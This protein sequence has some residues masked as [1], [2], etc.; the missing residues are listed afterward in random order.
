[1]GGRN[2]QECLK[3]D[4]TG[5]GETESAVLEVDESPQDFLDGG[6]VPIPGRRLLKTD[7]VF[8]FAWER[9]ISFLHYS[10]NEF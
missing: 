7:G 2:G 8:C 10:Q 1:M 3:V 9:R 4:N 5:G 6:L